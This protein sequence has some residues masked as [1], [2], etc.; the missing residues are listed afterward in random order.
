MCRTFHFNEYER[1]AK[2]ISVLLRVS[3]VCSVILFSKLKLIE[4]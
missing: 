4:R 1:D 3:S 2:N